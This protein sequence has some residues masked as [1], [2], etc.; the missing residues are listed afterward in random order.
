MR[1]TIVLGSGSSE[2][3]GLPSTDRIT[4]SVRSGEGVWRHTDGVYRRVPYQPT[5]PWNAPVKLLTSALFSEIEAYYRDKSSRTVDYEDC[6]YLA[7][8]LSDA[9]SGE[10]DNPAVQPLIEK[11]TDKEELRALTANG[12]D[13]RR[14]FDETVNYI[15]DVVWDMLSGRPTSV[16]HLNWLIDM[17]RDKS[18]ESVDLVNLN[19]DRVLEQ[20]LSCNLVS[21]CDGFGELVGAVRLWEPDRLE[22]AR[23]RLIK[24][25]GSIDWFLLPNKKIGIVG[26]HEAGLTTPIITRPLLLV[27]TFN[28]MTEYTTGI[29]ADLHCHFHRCLHQTH[30]L[31]CCGYGFGDKGINR[32]LSEWINADRQKR[33]I[34]VHA[35]P[36]EALDGGRPA[37]A[38]NWRSWHKQKKLLFVKKWIQDVS[39]DQVKQA[40]SC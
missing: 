3:A 25:H 24:L 15:R 21:F 18:V 37:I 33:L 1:L 26:S 5:S 11:L 12:G 36:G 14:L 7:A 30:F 8:Q 23:V 31:V 17:V 13:R 4:K 38:N 6:C 32:K 40:L 35:K 2:P 9:E 20:V 34:L 27:G 10:F 28:K 19:H 39:W 16:Q 22:G 29:F